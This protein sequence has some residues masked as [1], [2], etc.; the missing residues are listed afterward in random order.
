MQVIVVSLSVKQ[1]TA[2]QRLGETCTAKLWQPF[3]IRVYG[4]SRT[5]ASSFVIKAHHLVW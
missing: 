5:A 4:T 3:I 1:F 2:M